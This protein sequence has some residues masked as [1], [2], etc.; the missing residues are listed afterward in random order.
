MAWI[1]PLLNMYLLDGKASTHNRE[2]IFAIIRYRSCNIYIKVLM[3]IDVRAKNYRR[4]VLA[5][6]GKNSI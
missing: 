2:I 5:V 4:R 3:P 1:L 6:N